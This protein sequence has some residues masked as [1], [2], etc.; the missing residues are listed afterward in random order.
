MEIRECGTT[1]PT[2]NVT[3]NFFASTTGVAFKITGSGSGCGTTFDGSRCW[4]VTA[5]GDTSYCNVTTTEIGICGSLTNCSPP[6]APPV[7]PVPPV[8]AVV[9]A[10]YLDCDGFDA[11]V[12]V[13]GPSGTTFPNVLKISGICY[14][15]STLGGSTGAL[16]SNYD[17]F[18]SCSLCQATTPT[19]PTPPPSPPTPTCFAINNMSTGSS[20]TLA[21]NP[22]RFETMYFNN[23]SFCQASNFF[24]TDANCSNSVADTYVANGSYYREWSNGQF[25]PCLIC[26]Q[27]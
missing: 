6:P 16:Y 8:P 3:V 24:R 14:Q 21:C 19:P 10:Q 25:G 20:P 12:Y 22:L 4:E 23:S 1:S 2:Y 18:A 27:Q 5:L 17:D 15:Y 13:S 26:Q 9:Y 7:P 11:V